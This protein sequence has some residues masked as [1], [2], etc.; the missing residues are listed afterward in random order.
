MQVAPP[1][2]KIDP[3]HS[4]AKYANDASRAIWWPKLQLMQ[5]VPTGGQICN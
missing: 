1:D 4:V 5:V 3:I 2:D